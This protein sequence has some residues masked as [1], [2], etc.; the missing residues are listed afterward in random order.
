MVCPRFLQ[1]HMADA[2][3]IWRIKDAS[4]ELRLPL[5]MGILNVTPDSF[6]DGGVHHGSVADAVEHAAKML[7]QG[8]GI[9]DIGG[10]S[11]RPGSEP[12]SADEELERVLP[13]ISE[14]KARHPAAVIS[15]DTYKARVADAAVG[16]GAAIVN[17]ISAGRL[18]PELLPFAAESG[19]GYV[20][21]HMLGTP[22][23][24]QREPHYDDPVAE[25]H[26]FLKERLHRLAEAGIAPE[27]VVL[28]PGIGFGKR[29]SDNLALIANAERLRVD[30]R[31]LLFGVSRKSFLGKLLGQGPEQRLAGTVAANAL[32][33]RQGVDILRVH[34]VREAVDTVKL[35]LALLPQRPRTGDKC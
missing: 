22:R 33:L 17:D 12:L 10:E 28:D 4:L 32:L 6:Y 9:I 5:V 25:I 31:P 23:D 11:S 19:C 35:H 2:W 15:I 30:G 3:R 20:L 26:A 13:V 8:A 16:A 18:D 14:L 27:R 29:L 7:E 1:Q 21:M 34:D 24:M